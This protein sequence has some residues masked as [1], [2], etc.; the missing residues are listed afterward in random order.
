MTHPEAPRSTTPP[1]T[2][3]Q[4]LTRAEAATRLRIAPG[5]LDAHARNGHLRRYYPPGGAGAPRFRIE[6][7][8]ALLH[9]K[10]TTPPAGDDTTC[11]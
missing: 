11:T 4:W 10:T 3:R 9:P 8:D 6:D 1:T 5:T 7:V 2:S